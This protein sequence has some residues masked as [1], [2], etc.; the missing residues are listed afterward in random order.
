MTLLNNY[1]F[2]ETAQRIE[3]RMDDATRGENWFTRFMRLANAMYSHRANNGRKQ[4][5]FLSNMAKFGDSI[6]L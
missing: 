5:S 4:T 2:Q 3:S 1:T 6:Y